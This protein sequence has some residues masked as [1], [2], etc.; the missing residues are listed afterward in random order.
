MP[1]PAQSSTSLLH[2]R[3]IPPRPAGTDRI[4]YRVVDEYD[5]D[6]LTPQRTRSSTRPSKDILEM[7][8][9]DRPEP[10]AFTRPSAAF[11]PQFE[12]AVRAG[13]DGWYP[14]AEQEEDEDD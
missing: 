13:I 10:Q 7:D 9:L 2:G 14:E 5:G 3:R 11:Y 6:T 4:L 12:A 8:E 1:L